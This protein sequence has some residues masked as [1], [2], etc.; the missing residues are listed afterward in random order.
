M[1]HLLTNGGVFVL[2]TCIAVHWKVGILLLQ[3]IGCDIGAM[4]FEH[5]EKCFWKFAQI[6]CHSVHLSCFFFLQ[7]HYGVHSELLLEK[8]NQSICTS[9]KQVGVN[10]RCHSTF[11]LSF[12]V[13]P[14]HASF[15]LSN[16]DERLLS[17]VSC[18]EKY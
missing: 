7:L 2:Y 10:H 8:R 12:P 5:C 11:S 9:R 14:C 18:I 1:I 13:F 3:N 4:L 17:L 16:F 6:H 15:S